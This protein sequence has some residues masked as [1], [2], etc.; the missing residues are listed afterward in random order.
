MSLGM[1]ATLARKHPDLAREWVGDAYADLAGGDTNAPYER[2]DGM[3]PVN[4]R[5]NASVGPLMGMGMPA[6]V[7][8]VRVAVRN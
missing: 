5:Y 8:S 7:S 6:T 4:N 1:A 2:I 3:H